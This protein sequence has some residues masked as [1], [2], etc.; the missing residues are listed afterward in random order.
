[1]KTRT[2]YKCHQ[3]EGIG[4]RELRPYGPEGA[5]VCAGCVFGTD[6]NGP[7]IDLLNEARYQLSKRLMGSEP[8]LLDA[9]E[10]VGP[11]PLST[12]SRDN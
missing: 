6:G 11:R 4:K 5:D 8:L 12:R 3:P 1:M 7:N 2:C 10:Q 9:T